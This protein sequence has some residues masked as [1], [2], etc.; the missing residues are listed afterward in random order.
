M[1]LFDEVAQGILLAVLLPTTSFPKVQDMWWFEK[2]K[3]LMPTIL[4]MQT[5]EVVENSKI[6]PSKMVVQKPGAP[7]I[8]L[9]I[10]Y[11][12]CPA[13]ATLVS[14]F[15]DDAFSDNATRQQIRQIAQEHYGQNVPTKA[16]FVNVDRGIF[17]VEP[18]G[19]SLQNYFTADAMQLAV[20]RCLSAGIDASQISTITFYRG[21]KNLLQGE[22]IEDGML[23]EV[24][25]VDA[26]QGRQND[27]VFVDAS[28]HGSCLV[29][30]TSSSR[31]GIPR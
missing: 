26:Y 31:S 5:S 30:I 16:V 22:K 11:R 24:G 29:I 13:I 17:R 28:L 8:L 20:E 1:A 18:N 7:M 25:T 23:R 15:Y 2:I 21:Q 9:N 14:G 19:T 10:Q 3:Q 4:T 27:V 6:S 12:V